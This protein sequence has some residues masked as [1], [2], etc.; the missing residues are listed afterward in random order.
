VDAERGQLIWN[1]LKLT[2]SARPDDGLMLD[3]GSLCCMT[4]QRSR[5]ARCTASVQTAN[6]DVASCFPRC[7]A[8]GAI[9]NLREGCCG[10]STDRPFGD[11]FSVRACRAITGLIFVKRLVWSQ[12]SR[13][14]PELIR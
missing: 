4:L 2:G 1:A 6:L 10:P 3:G 13:R 12:L 11:E 9:A 5:V 8:Y 14:R 7:F